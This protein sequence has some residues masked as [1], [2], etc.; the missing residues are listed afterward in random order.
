MAILLTV[1]SLV[2]PKTSTLVPVG[3][4][5][6]QVAPP[7]VSLSSTSYCQ[8]G[9]M[10]DGQQTYVGAVAGNLWQLGTWLHVITGSHA[11]ETV[12]VLDRIGWGSQLDFFSWS[13]KRAWDYGRQQIL[14][15]VVK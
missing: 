5:L 10:A 14:V 11:G 1:L 6:R 8:S 7:V 13:C 2:T 4:P 3:Y 9:T 15:E 12:Q